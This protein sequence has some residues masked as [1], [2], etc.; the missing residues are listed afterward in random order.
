VA[1]I[2]LIDDVT[3]T[4]V[5]PGSN[6]LVEYDPSSQWYAASIAIAAGWL[7]QGG[8]VSYN[9]LAQPPTN[10][11]NALKRIGVDPVSLEAEPAAPSE[12][13]RIWDWYTQTLGLKST[14]KLTSPIKAADL[15]IMFSREQ[16]KMEPDPLRL[17]I[18]DDWSTFARFNDE[19][20]MVEF[21]L[22][23]AIPLATVLK[24]TGIAGLMRGVHSEWVYSRI[25]AANDGI[26]DVKAEEVGGEVKNLFRIRTMRNVGFDSR[27]HTLKIGENFDVTVER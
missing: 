1:R 4:P 12:R 26:V 18:T 9:T 10:V 25:E 16:F 8:S 22:T 23:R 6:I 20:S 24:A 15:S 21:T 13:L 19:K 27:W 7:K 2:P 5:P 17:R 14:E 3:N 11:R